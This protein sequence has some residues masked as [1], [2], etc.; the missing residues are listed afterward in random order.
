MPI[1]AG[2]SMPEPRVFEGGY[3]SPESLPGHCDA[4]T[5]EPLRGMD[6]II[7]HI[8]HDLRHPLAAVLANAEL[9]TQP[10]MSDEE[11]NNCYQEIRAGIERMGELVSS[12]V[13]RS[14]G[15]ENRR[16]L[17]ANGSTPP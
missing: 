14:R 15:H 16:S 17:R 6:K 2:V 8:A 11:R 5:L 9:L 12:L 13:E 4:S 1:D 7:A 3:L 10:E